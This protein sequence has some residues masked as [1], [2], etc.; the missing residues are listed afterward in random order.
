MDHARFTRVDPTTWRIKPHGAMR[1]PAIIYADENLIRDM[2]D[3]VFEQAVNVATLPGSPR[4]SADLRKRHRQARFQ[5]H[6][7][8]P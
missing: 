7:Q 3:K 4:N 8:V 1:V 2:D 6:H 5:P